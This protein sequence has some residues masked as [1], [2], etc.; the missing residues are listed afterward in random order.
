VE[1]GANV[2]L[3]RPSDGSTPL[4]VAS[5]AGHLDLVRFLVEQG[6]ADLNTQ[7]D[8]GRT[9]LDE[10]CRRGHLNVI[11]LLLHHSLVARVV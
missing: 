9:P 10:A 6:R 1:L 3:Q 11:R 5:R 4:H 2:N 7:D 8:L